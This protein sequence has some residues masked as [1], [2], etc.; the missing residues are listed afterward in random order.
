MFTH[1][2]AT[3]T[4]PWSY[5][6]VYGHLDDTSKFQSLSLPEQLNVMADKLAK[7]A[8]IEAVETGQHSEPYFYFPNESIRVLVNKNKATTLSYSC[9][10]PILYTGRKYPLVSK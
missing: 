9:L 8:L 10:L 4:V 1:N 2:L 6:H 7:E 5:Q 3:T